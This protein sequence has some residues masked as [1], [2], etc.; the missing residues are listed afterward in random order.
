MGL[1]TLDSLGKFL[2]LRGLTKPP[3]FSGHEVAWGDFKFRLLCVCSLLQLDGLMEAAC[4]CD[5]EPRLEEMSQDLQVRA[6]LLYNVLVSCCSGR[7]LTIIR[8]VPAYNGFAA[9]RRLAAEFEPRLPSR[10]A[11]MLAG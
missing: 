2:D 1:P 5:H 10:V 8:G 9:W 3:T 7:G 11:A 6:R 4:R